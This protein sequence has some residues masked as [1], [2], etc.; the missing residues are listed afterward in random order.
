MSI[1]DLAGDLWYNITAENLHSD[2]EYGAVGDVSHGACLIHVQKPI[3]FFNTTSS[4]THHINGVTEPNDG[5]L[6]I[7]THT[8][9]Y[10]RV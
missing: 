6:S 4:K 8:Y 10:K 1:G 5:R 7:H 9:I 3:N 2:P